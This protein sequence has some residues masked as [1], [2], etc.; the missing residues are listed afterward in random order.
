M[1][2]PYTFRWFGEKVVESVLVVIIGYL[3]YV[4]GNGLLQAYL[5]PERLL[6]AEELMQKKFDDKIKSARDESLQ[7]ESEI[8]SKLEKMRQ[9]MSEILL[10]MKKGPQLPPPFDPSVPTVPKPPVASK[11]DWNKLETDVQK[12]DP[13]KSRLEYLEKHLWNQQQQQQRQRP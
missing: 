10:E 1:A 2:E 7:R 3:A 4:A 6:K 9:E 8:F 12:I 11:I 5:L 13:E